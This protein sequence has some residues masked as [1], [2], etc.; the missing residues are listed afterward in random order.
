MVTFVLGFPLLRSIFPTRIIAG[1]RFGRLVRIDRS[2]PRF[3]EFDRK[4][5]RLN[6]SHGYIS[7]A[8]FCL[9]KKKHFELPVLYPRNQPEPPPSSICPLFLPA[10]PSTI[11]RRY[12]AISWP[13]G[14]L[15]ARTA[16]PLPPP[17]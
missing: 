11:I 1:R 16:L 7:Y 17:L 6:S 10:L 13:H 4:S 3:L 8:V 9:K 14:L 15:P 2:E 12:I 5:T